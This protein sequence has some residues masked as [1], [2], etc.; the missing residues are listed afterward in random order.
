[1]AKRHCQVFGQCQSRPA[2]CLATGSKVR[3]G[4]QVQSSPVT[5]SFQLQLRLWNAK[6]RLCA[7]FRVL[8]A[9]FL[10]SCEMRSFVVGWVVS[11][12]SNDYIALLLSVKQ[13]Q[14]SVQYVTVQ[15]LIEC[16]S[17]I[18]LILSSKLCLGFPDVL[19]DFP[20]EIK[21]TF[22]I[23]APMPSTSWLPLSKPA[24][25]RKGKDPCLRVSHRRYA[26]ELWKCMKN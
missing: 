11:D 21:H 4:D 5:A 22:H 14:E 26:L 20:A 24:Y 1:M 2:C 9:T 19:F 17:Y 7:R 12:I 16:F 13:F 15:L 8:K 10:K 23:L 6:V 3:R 18:N 25:E